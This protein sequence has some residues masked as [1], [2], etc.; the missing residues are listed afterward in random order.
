MKP[1][2]IPIEYITALMPIYRFRIPTAY[3]DENGHMN[4]RWY[5][6]IF[7]DAGYPFV[8]NFGMTLDYHAAHHTGGFDLEHHIHYL[9]EVRL[10]DMVTIYSR[11]LGRSAKCIHYMMFMVNDTQTALAAT[12]ECVNAFAD[13]TIRRTA[14]YPEA[15]A[16]QIDKQLEIDLKLAWSAPVSGVMS[17]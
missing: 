11:I 15:I 6:A 9:K 13:L 12:F 14:S 2:A 4:M 1:P 17:V 10:D 3:L 8:A 7:D 5:L 16:T